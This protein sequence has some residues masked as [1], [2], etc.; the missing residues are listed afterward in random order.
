MTR[1][2]IAAAATALI[3]AAALVLRPDP[4]GTCLTCAAEAWGRP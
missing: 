2:L 4:P 1:I 3:L